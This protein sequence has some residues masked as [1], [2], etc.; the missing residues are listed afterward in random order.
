MTAAMAARGL[1]GLA[2]SGLGLW[3]KPAEF[4][5]WDLRLYSPLRV[6]LGGLTGYVARRHD[7]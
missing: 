4:R 3:S 7:A 2:G 6:A 5:H 1:G